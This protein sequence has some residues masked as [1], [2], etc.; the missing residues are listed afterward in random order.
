[1]TQEEEKTYFPE[2]TTKKD[3]NQKHQRKH[4]LS[5]SKIKITTKRPWAEK[6]D[7][8]NYNYSFPKQLK[9]K[10]KKKEFQTYTPQHF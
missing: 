10:K 4:K 2:L 8:C 7:K 3:K 6:P 5:N 9:N 1:M